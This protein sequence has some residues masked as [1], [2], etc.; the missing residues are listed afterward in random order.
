[1][2]TRAVV[3]ETAVHEALERHLE[4]GGSRSEWFNVTASEARRVVD[5]ILPGERR[6]DESRRYS[7]ELT[8]YEL[9]M[10]ELRIPES[11]W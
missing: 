4:R 8:G 2:S 6:A 7:G 9:M 11:E 3:Y 10:W 1:M 5:G